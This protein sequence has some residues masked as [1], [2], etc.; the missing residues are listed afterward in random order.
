MECLERRGGGS[1][2]VDVDVA[3][4]V[5]SEFELVVVG[6]STLQLH[7]DLNIDNNDHLQR[8]YL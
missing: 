5:K 4:V 8:L 7:D 2:S 3:P 1:S 6:S